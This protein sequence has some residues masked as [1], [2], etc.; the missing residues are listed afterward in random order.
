MSTA[1]AKATF[2]GA[3]S[4]PDGLFTGVGPGR[5]WLSIGL[6][7]PAAAEGEPPAHM[8]TTLR[9]GS[10]RC[11]SSVTSFRGTDQAICQDHDARRQAGE[12]RVQHRGEEGPDGAVELRL[13]LELDSGAVDQ[14]LGPSDGLGGIGS[15]NDDDPVVG[16]I[17]QVDEAPEGIG[18]GLAIWRRLLEKVSRSSVIVAAM[19][20]SEAGTAQGIGSRHSRQDGQASR[21]VEELGFHL[22]G[23]YLL[24]DVQVGRRRPQSGPP[25]GLGA[26]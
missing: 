7:M 2:V 16:G 22:F 25:V 19:A 13:P 14:L 17:L 26:R 1:P 9:V 11:Q 18:H 21:H 5:G 20:L 23:E 15:G 24:G 3:T 10:S 6:A 12:S 4:R 8:T